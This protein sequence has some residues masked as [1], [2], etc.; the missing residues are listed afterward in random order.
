MLCRMRTTI[1]MEDELLRRAKAAA[2]RNGESLTAF[3]EV[4]IRYQLSLQRSSVDAGF[5]L[6]VFAGTGLRPNVDLDDSAAL[7]GLMEDH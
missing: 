7:L 4:A 6:P 2:A 5:D 3:I 1:R